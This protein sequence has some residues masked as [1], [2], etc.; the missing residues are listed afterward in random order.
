VGEGPPLRSGTPPACL[1]TGATGLLGGHVVRELLAR[2]A[3]EVFVTVR[4][5]AGR[6]AGERFAQLRR[7]HAGGERLRLVEA[8]DGSAPALPESLGGIVHCAALVDFTNEDRVLEANV[9]ATWHLLCAASR[10]TGLRRFLHVGSLTIRTDSARAF[11]EA[12]LDTGQ[13]FVSPY[14]L[15]KFLAETMIRKLHRAA[16]VTVVR[17]GSIL[18]DGGDLG[19]ATTDWFRRTARLWAQGR[20]AAVPMAPDQAIHPVIAGDLAALLAELLRSDDLPDVLH[21]PARPGP[22][23]ERIFRLLG[24]TL[25]RPPPRLLAQDSDEWRRVRETMP[26]P[27]RRVVDGLYPPPPP[28]RRLAAVDSRA[29]E[30]WLGRHD[31][32]NPTIADAYW[33]R[34]AASLGPAAAPELAA[35]ALEEIT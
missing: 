9:A 3:P 12:D 30:R 27:V 6:T 22:P 4:S 1:V 23:A 20:L 2:G 18:P 34:L 17:A 19:G 33:A 35:P 25:R 28:G 15:T 10:L 31:L 11:T 13:S 26:V 8:D 16:P 21:L 29:S 32:P 14:A 5:K 7:A 24:E